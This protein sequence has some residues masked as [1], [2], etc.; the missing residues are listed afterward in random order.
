M[1]VLPDYLNEQTEQAIRER[2]LGR[3]PADIDKAEGSYIW[4]AISPVAWELYTASIWAQDVLSRGF[5]ST[6]FGAYLDLRCEE[7]GLTRRPASKA[8]GTVRF[9]GTA[10]T[11]VAAGVRV[12]TAADPATNSASVEFE[13]TEAVV[14][15]GS[16]QA[17]AAMSA[18][19][20]GASG[21]VVAGSVILAVYALPGVTAITN[22]A[23][24]SGGADV[25]SDESLL[26]RYY[27]KVRSPGASGNRSDYRLWALEVSGV[28]AAYVQPLWNGPGTVRVFVADTEK[29][30]PS[31][32]LVTA[33]QQYIAPASGTGDGKAPIGATVTVAAA[34]EVP[35]N[36]VA[37]LTL[38][39]G[40][41]V[42]GV[43]TLFENEMRDYLKL[44][45]FADPIVR[46]SRVASLL[47]DIPG[48]VDFS[49][50]TVNGGGAN[51]QMTTGQVAVLGTVMFSG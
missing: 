38:A 27:V 41:T 37:S 20:P 31:S 26:E 43:R 29:R 8:T 9:T 34:T 51:V 18:V 33:V 7:H 4:D 6:T 12:S 50:L 44:L 46:Y 19:E 49:G 28:G 23:A 48:I 17:V 22:T 1:A 45:A 35:I 2:M 42:S 47:L 40:A 5:A 10:G 13:T 14:L 21:N 25:E 39:S 24:A 32:G 36:V 11:S 3:I 30:A 15:D 16:G